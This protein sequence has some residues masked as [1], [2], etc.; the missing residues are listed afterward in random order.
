MTIFT[1]AFVTEQTNIHRNADQ[2]LYQLGELAK[3]SDKSGLDTI[4]M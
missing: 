3:V 4:C 1:V 2:E